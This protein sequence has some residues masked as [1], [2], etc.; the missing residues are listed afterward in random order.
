VDLDCIF[1]D[2]PECP[3]VRLFNFSSAEVTRLQSVIAELATN[4]VDRV[5][6]HEMPGTFSIDGFELVLILLDWDQGLVCV[7]PSLFRCGYTAGTW[8]NV[9]G[10]IDPFLSGSSGYQWLAGGPGEPG[11]LLSV[12]GEW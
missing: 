11:L 10:L 3:L 5:P 1:P 7:G 12:S 8:D 6:V 9:D 2:S 4:R